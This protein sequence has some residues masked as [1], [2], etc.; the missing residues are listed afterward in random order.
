MQDALPAIFCSTR[1]S[2]RLRLD[3]SIATARTRFGCRIAD[4]RARCQFAR[5]IASERQLT[6]IFSLEDGSEAASSLDRMSSLDPNQSAI[7]LESPSRSSPSSDQLA[8]RSAGGQ[9]K[10]GVLNVG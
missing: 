3:R 8:C 4:G 10:L 7:P 6:G 2:C 1:P 5:T 9:G